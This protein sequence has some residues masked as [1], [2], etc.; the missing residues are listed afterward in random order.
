[1]TK[2][3]AD[4]SFWLE[5]TGDS[6]EPRAALSSNEEV[7][8]AIIGGGYSGLWTAY[9]LLRGQPGLRV[10][11]VEQEICGYGG[12]GRNGGW[13]SPR[14]PVSASRLRTLYG[15]ETARNLLLSV[16]SSVEEIRNVCEEER[17]EACFRAAGTLTLARTTRQLDA[18]R[19]SYAAYD[20]LGLADRYRFMSIEDAADRIR[21]TGVHGALYTPDGASIHPGRLVRGLAHAVEAHGGV[22][23]EQ[24]T[25]DRFEAGANP[26]VVTHAGELRA[27][28]AVII[29]TEAYTTRFPR[30]HRALLPV[31]S[32]ICLTE[33][34]TQQQWDQ[35][36]WHAGENVASARNTVVY[37]TKTPDGRI[38]FGS[39]GAPYRFGSVMSDAQDRHAATLA[40]IQQSLRDWFPALAGIRFTH[41][42]GGPVAMPRD[43]MPAVNFDSR[44]HI[45]FIGGYTGQGVSTSNMMGRLMAG[46][47][48]QQ[49][50]G[51]EGLPFAQRISPRWPIEPLRWLTVRYMQNALLRIDE[52]DE[53]GSRRPP[54]AWIAE[55]LGR[56]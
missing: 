38:L 43:W 44:E 35:I 36:G 5:D 24:T 33:P 42:W 29:A 37:L 46:M 22:I 54:D 3:Y 12:S 4:Y 14:F 30:L 23:Y 10:A 1:M 31:Y 20:H 34:L 17:I 11:V 41:N 6:L 39:R 9:Y 19:S 48:T 40:S 45:G 27:K 49:Q 52:A 56:H 47:I 32:L 7:D 53:T 8:V 26:R 16:Q 25:V 18:I 13:C 28:Q 15:R 55:F 2:R 50:T 21:V 51:L